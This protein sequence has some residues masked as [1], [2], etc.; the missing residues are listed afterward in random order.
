MCKIASSE[1]GVTGGSE[2]QFI[3]VINNQVVNDRKL[4]LQ[5]YCYGI[6]CHQE[7]LFLT[8][9][10]VLYMYSLDGKIVSKL[11]EDNLNKW[12]GKN[13]IGFISMIKNISIQQQCPS[14]Y[15]VLFIQIVIN[16]YSL[17][18]RS[19]KRKCMAVKRIGFDPFFMFRC[20][21]INIV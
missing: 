3:K 7:D 12:T 10:T 2:V 19:M 18:D 15:A 4:K 8:S 9:V 21:Q 6:A 13:H 20:Y 5:H 17:H 14:I 1:V 11:H 16:I